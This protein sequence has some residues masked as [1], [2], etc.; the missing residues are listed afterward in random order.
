L[1]RAD[2]T[3]DL[4]AVLTGLTVLLRRR[5][6]IP[7]RRG[8]TVSLRR[9]L[10]RRRLPLRRRLELRSGGDGHECDGQGRSEAGERS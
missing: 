5:L 10:L 1:T 6:T 2:L 4:P 7:L 3:T 9:R 8:L